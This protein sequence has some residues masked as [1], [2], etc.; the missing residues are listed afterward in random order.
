MAYDYNEY[1]KNYNKKNVVMVSVRLNRSK[2]KDIIEA[3]NS[4]GENKNECVKRLVR[5]GLSVKK[6]I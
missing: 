4:E 5:M 3:L 6:S 1:M 2:D